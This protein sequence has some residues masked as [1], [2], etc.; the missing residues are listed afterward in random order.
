MANVQTKTKIA[1]VKLTPQQFLAI[2]RRA[3]QCGVRTSTWMRSMLTQASNRR[4]KP[5]YIRIRE[6]SGA[7]S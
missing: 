5:G 1:S 7:T 4:G 6:P 3:E 2:E